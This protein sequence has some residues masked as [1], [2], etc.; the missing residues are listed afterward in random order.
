[1]I[2]RY[3]YI[4]S[5]L[6]ILSFNSQAEEARTFKSITGQ[7]ILATYQGIDGDKV[8]LMRADGKSF[9][10]PMQKLSLEDQDY[11]NSVAK[12]ITSQISDLNTAANHDIFSML[13]FDKT[14]SADLAKKLRLRQE[15]KSKYGISW[16]H[17]AA[18]EKGYLLF[19]AMP[20]SLALYSYADG[21]PSSISAVYANKG[22]FGSKSGFGEDH[23]NGGTSAIAQTLEE[24]MA[25]D[26]QA[27]IKT[28]SGVL[29]AGKEQRYGE[30]Q[31]RR[32]IIRWDWNG[33]A[34]LLS[35]EEGEYVALSVISTEKANGGGK[36]E[37][38][39]DSDLKQRLIASLVKKENGDIYISEIPMVDQGPKG[40][41]VPATF[42]RMMRTMGLDADMYLLA[43]I[44][45]SK[46]GGGT[47][48]KLLTEKIKSEIYRKGRRMKEDKLKELKI[49][50]IKK[51][52][53]S[54][55]PIMW[56][57][58]SV[59][60]YN[61]IA[62]KI[63]SKRDDTG[64][65]NEHVKKIAELNAKFSDRVK[66]NQASNSHMCMIIG[67][68]DKSNEIA[69]SDSWGERFE[70]RWI[71]IGIANWVHQEYIFSILP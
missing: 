54:G 21:S 34:F 24:A 50:D 36:S 6:I 51:Y 44:G 30:G 19:G 68:N 26:E 15:S 48:P 64:N 70:L 25:N 39:K 4:L 20:Y 23:F 2:N 46:S 10:L 47:S 71:P 60:E 18:Y 62:D 53:D 9:L 35:N 22:D 45:E 29:G 42:E 7:S 32:K 28:I 33:H 31:T 52:I 69:V 55:A 61:E 49:R 16:R 40:Y 65:W 56:T 14:K 11:I 27:I 43:M 38:M 3:F 59:N 37:Q 63:T 8:S 13:S 12:K 66:P 57:M 41:C 1:V 58:S 17:Y 5:L 67:Y